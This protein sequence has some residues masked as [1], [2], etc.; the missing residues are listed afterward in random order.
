MVHIVWIV[1]TLIAVLGVVVLIVPKVLRKWLSFFSKG[2]LVYIPVVLRIVLG[3]LFLIYARETHVP[4]VIILFGI[5][6]TGAGI[7]FLVMPYQN[8]DKLLKWWIDQP[9]WVYRV[10]AI[11]AAVLGG[12]IMYAGVPE[13]G[14]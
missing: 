3:V 7:I 14:V 6:M 10:W 13:T 8:T 1:G 4:W 2:R 5:L 11:V 12:I 9:I